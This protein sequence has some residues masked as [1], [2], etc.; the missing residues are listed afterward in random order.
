MDQQNR[1][2]SW[3]EVLVRKI[4]T[5]PNNLKIEHTYLGVEVSEERGVLTEEGS[6]L[7]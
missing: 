1:K 5:K 7:A 2:E 4:E 3:D 6:G